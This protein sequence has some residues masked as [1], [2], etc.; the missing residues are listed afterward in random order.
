MDK[1]GGVSR[2]SVENICLT[3]PRNFAGKPFS[4]SLLSGAEKVWI[5][6]GWGVSRFSFENFRLTVPRNFAGKPFSV[7]LLSG[8]E[9]FWIR[10]GVGSIKI[11]C[12][13][14]LSQSAEDFR[15]ETF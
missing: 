12:R 8:A 2:F 14:V 3:V 1:R 11:F 15:R 7:S 10:E 13:N 5:R 6:E 4:V 9:N